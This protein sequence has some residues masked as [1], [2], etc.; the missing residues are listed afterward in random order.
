MV[1]GEILDIPYVAAQTTYGH[2]MTTMDQ[3]EPVREKVRL[4][5]VRRIRAIHT[6]C[7]MVL[8]LDHRNP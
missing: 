2:T 3:I 4:P 7:S 8:F 5:V 6:P 1:E